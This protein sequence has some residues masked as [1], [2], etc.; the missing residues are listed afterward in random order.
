M[1]IDSIL[2]EWCYRLPKG[3]PAH[4]RD[5]EVL[6]HVLLETADVSPE[7]ARQ[8]VERAKGEMTHLISESV[9]S[10]LSL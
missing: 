5:Y 8:I 10:S 1:N 3:Y 7:Y 2:T 9:I 4:V 6:Y